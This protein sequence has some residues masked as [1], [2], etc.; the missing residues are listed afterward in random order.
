MCVVV[1]NMENAVNLDFEEIV[2]VVLN[3]HHVQ[4][5]LTLTN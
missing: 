4:A 5:Q 2:S 1:C 3:V